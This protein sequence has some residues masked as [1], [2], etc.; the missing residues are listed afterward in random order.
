MVDP[1]IHWYHQTTSHIGV[2]HLHTVISAHFYHPNIDE[3]IKHIVSPCPQCQIIITPTTHFG[4]LSSRE[5]P[6]V[7]WRE[8][9]VD[10]IGP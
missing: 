5:A 1:L 9:H 10:S 6:M 4:K 7:P 8:V 3:R 2:W